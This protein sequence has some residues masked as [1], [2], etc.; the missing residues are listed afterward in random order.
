MTV[1]Q[2]EVAVYEA[3][4]SSDSVSFGRPIGHPKDDGIL[5]LH[6]Y[7]RRLLPLGDT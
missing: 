6:T 7:I 5:T 1:A 2:N 4:F 3:Y